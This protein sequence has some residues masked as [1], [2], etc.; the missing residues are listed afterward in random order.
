MAWPAAEAEGEAR[1]GPLI[2]ASTR[3]RLR[4]SLPSAGRTARDGEGEGVAERSESAQSDRSMFHLAV[5]GD[6]GWL[7]LARACAACAACASLLA[8]TR[9]ICSSE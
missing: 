1:E 2:R 6:L 9:L 4:T 8:K 5:A 7:T 3:A